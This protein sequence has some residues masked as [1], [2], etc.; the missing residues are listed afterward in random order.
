MITA[1]GYRSPTSTATPTREYRE[2]RIDWDLSAAEKGGYEYFMLKEIA[3]QPA[4]V[5]DTLLG[6]FVDGRIVL[7]EQRLSDQELRE[8]DK[9]FVVACGTAYHSGCWPIRHRALDPAAGGGGAGQR[10]P[11]PRP[12]AGP[13]HPGGG[14]LAV[15]GDR[16]HA[17]GGAARQTAEGQGAGHLQHQRLPDSAGVRRG[18]L[19]PRRAPR[20]GSRRP[21]RFWRRSPPTIWSGWRWRRP[22]APSTA[23][24]W[25][26]ITASWK[27]CPS[28]WRGCWPPWNRSRSWPAGSRRR[29]RCCSWAATSA[30]RW[31]W[32]G[33]SSSRSWPTCTP[34]G[35]P[36]VSSSTARSR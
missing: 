7:D 5:A 26:G 32:R 11:L 8:V 1:D 10:V 2:F 9:V 13:Q 29:R 36:P 18:A 22:A 27:R 21:R 4:A 12:G 20:S 24:R 35:S 30:T 19:H 15:R 28:W 17:G 34:R 16:R 6:H 23:T 31:R 33:R 14:D 3:E 25:P